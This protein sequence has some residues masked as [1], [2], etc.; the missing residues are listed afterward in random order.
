MCYLLYHIINI[1]YTFVVNLIYI[2]FYIINKYMDL[3]I[4]Y[5][6]LTYISLSNLFQYIFHDLV[7]IKFI[8]LNTFHLL[9]NYI[10]CF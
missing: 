2:H 8:H 1:E 9:N 3:L 5:I 10:H 7:H 4:Y 6:C